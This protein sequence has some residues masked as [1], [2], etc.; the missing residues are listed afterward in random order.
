VD[1]ADLG[2]L[3][4]LYEQWAAQQSGPLLRNER[5]WRR[6]KLGEGADDSGRRPDAYYWRDAEGSP[7][8]YLIYQ[9]EQAQGGQSEPKERLVVWDW[10][11][12]D[13][14]AL[15]AL[16]L[17]LR[18]HDSQ[19][20]EVVITVPERMRFRALFDDP[21]F[22]VETYAELMLRLVDVEAALQ[23]RSYASE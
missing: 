4:S 19:A 14:Q 9:L 13:P 20:D 15:R 10:A 17:F 2:V 21:R 8:A 11:A 22:K 18:N 23:A 5:W 1:D 16:L 6:N 7:R 3:R 12:L